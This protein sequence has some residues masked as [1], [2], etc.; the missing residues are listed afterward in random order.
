MPAFDSPEMETAPLEKLYVSV[1][2]LAEKLPPQ[3]APDDPA[4]L[5]KLKPKE[6]LLLTAQP[7]AL[8][9]LERSIRTLLEMG[10]LARQ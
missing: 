6:L 7:P 10:A 4:Q 1:K 9:Q 3:P 8:G 2:Y 5:R